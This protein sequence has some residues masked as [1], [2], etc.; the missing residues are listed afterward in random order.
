MCCWISASQLDVTFY[1]QVDDV[2]GCEYNRQVP[3]W[4]PRNLLMLRSSVSKHHLRKNPLDLIHDPLLW[5]PASL[6]HPCKCGS[7]RGE[8]IILQ[9][10]PWLLSVVPWHEIPSCSILNAKFMVLTACGK[11]WD[12]G[13]SLD[14]SQAEFL[15]WTSNK[16]KIFCL[17]VTWIQ[18]QSN[19]FS[20]HYISTSFPED[21]A[22]LSSNFSD[23]GVS[24]FWPSSQLFKLVYA[25]F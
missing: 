7:A 12:L 15:N 22:F 2:G 1:F 13:L 17:A 3:W 14:R 5:I 16:N 18:L 10:R 6:M 23:I 4:H 25:I 11:R 9:S 24:F 19:V 8:Q 21:E 20:V